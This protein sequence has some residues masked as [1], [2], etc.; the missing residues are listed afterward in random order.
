[1]PTIS[2]TNTTNNVLSVYYRV[3]N[4]DSVSPLQQVDIQPRALCNEID[5]ATESHLQSFRESAKDFLEKGI[6]LEGKNTGKKA[7]KIHD[8]NAKETTKDLKSKGKK[9][10]ENVKASVD[11]HIKANL[12]VEIDSI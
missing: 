4:G 3:V 2:I 9:S 12:N 11:K 1:M 7:E 10:S 8:E 6:L 5:F